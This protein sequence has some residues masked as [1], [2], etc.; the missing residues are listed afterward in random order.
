MDGQKIVGDHLMDWASA[1]GLT[2]RWNAG[3][4]RLEQNDGAAGAVVNFP[5]GFWPYFMTL[6]ETRLEDALQSIQLAVAMQNRAP[7]GPD[8]HE[9]HIPLDLVMHS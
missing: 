2:L 5:R 3:A 1:Q 6:D 8:A 7:G 9:I 4:L